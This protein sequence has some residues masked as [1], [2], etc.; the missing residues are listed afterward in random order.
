MEGGVHEFPLQTGFPEP[1]TSQML[2][3][4]P[5]G[6][7]G[8]LV[9]AK[10]APSVQSQSMYPWTPAISSIRLKFN[11]LIGFL[12]FLMTSIPFFYVGWTS[13]FSRAISYSPR[14]EFVVNSN[15]LRAVEDYSCFDTQHNEEA[16]IDLAKPDVVV[17]AR[18][19]WEYD[20]IPGGP[21][22]RKAL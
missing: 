1:T 4:P 7:L 14:G 18:R 17:H 22:I 6:S 5:G 16:Q 10:Q 20:N 21:S 12:S 11:G 19:S 3:P 15:L 9:L 2:P 13:V 8:P